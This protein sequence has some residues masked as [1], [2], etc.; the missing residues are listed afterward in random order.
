ML[1]PMSA[2][3]YLGTKEKVVIPRLGDP[4]QCWDCNGLDAHNMGVVVLPAERVRSAFILSFRFRVVQNLSPTVRVAIEPCESVVQC[5][6][7]VDPAASGA[8]AV[9]VVPGLDQHG[10]GRRWT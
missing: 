4:D 10:G 6:D 8:T 5:V 7:A 3:P 1:V 2:G 9:G